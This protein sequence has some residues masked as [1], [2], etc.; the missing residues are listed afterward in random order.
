MKNND[1]TIPR[2]CPRCDRLLGVETMLNDDDRCKECGCRM[3]YYNGET[4][5]TNTNPNALPRE[6][7]E[8][9]LMTK[10]KFHDNGRETP[11]WLLRAVSIKRTR[12]K[13]QVVDK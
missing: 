10:L 13:R 6:M 11:D 7:V 8:A 12:G 9:S 3:A 1:L 5:E 2:R 4:Y